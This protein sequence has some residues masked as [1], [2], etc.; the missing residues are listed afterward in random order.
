MIIVNFNRD[1]PKFLLF[2]GA[3][4]HGYKGQVHI[5]GLVPKM[6]EKINTSSLEQ[7]KIRCRVYGTS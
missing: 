1:L 2:P 6:T 7:K 3:G 5:N 4:G